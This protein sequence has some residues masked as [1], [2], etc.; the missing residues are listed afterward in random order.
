[1]ALD[2]KQLT[3]LKAPFD[4]N[5]HQFINNMAYLNE[6]AITNRI[7]EVD[8]GWSMVVTGVYTRKST[9]EK[10]ANITVVTV[11]LTIAGSTRSG[12]GQAV[13]IASKSGNEANEAEK[14]AA[15]DAL[16]RAARLFGIGRYLLRL[17]KHVNDINTLGAW[18]DKVNQKLSERR[19]NA[20]EAT[21]RQLPKIPERVSDDIVN[22]IDPHGDFRPQRERD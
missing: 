12:V 15:T 22:G 19:D 18:L 14:S 20:P 21:T 7:E 9:G 4:V 1:M 5:E 16:K 6:F 11:D 2:E 8:P 17:P 13:T 3:Q 10:P